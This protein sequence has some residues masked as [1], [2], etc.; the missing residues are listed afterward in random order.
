MAMKNDAKFEKGIDLS[1]QNWYE[2]FKKFWPEHS[3]V[4]EI[5]T[6]M[7][8]FWPRYMMFEL[9][10]YRGVMFDGTSLKENWLV[11]PKLT[12]EIWQILIRALENLKN[13]HFNRLPLTKVYNVWAK[14]K[15]RW[16]MFDGT[17]DWCKIW[18]NQNENSKQPDWP[19]A[20]WKLYFTLEINE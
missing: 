17:E 3:K 11:L 6:L 9:R 5:C 8:C 16:V 15:C 14:K 1:V 10:K 2:E 20:V 7:G 13:L 19:D 18:R 12:R 4:S